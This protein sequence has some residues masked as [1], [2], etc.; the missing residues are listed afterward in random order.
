MSNFSVDNYIGKMISDDICC[1]S[2]IN[3]YGIIL[4]QFAACQHKIINDHRI[5]LSSKNNDD[6]IYL[7]YDNF[8]SIIREIDKLKNDLEI[9]KNKIED[10]ENAIR[11]APF[12]EE[13]QKAESEF[14]ELKIK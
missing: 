2:I 14:N 8:V 5:F 7:S 11:Y 9:M 12:S 6:L 3:K 13:Y 1:R 4:D 10:L